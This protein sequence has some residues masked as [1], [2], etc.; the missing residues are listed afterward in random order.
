MEPARDPGFFTLLTTSYA[1]YVGVPLV[2]PGCNALWLYEKAPFALLAHNTEADPRFI[3][4]NKTAQ[5]CF[6]YSWSEFIQLRSRFSAEA[7]NREE[8]QRS[9]DAVATRGFVS[10]YSGLRIAKS[11]RRFRIRDGVIWQLTDEQ[12]ISHGQAAIF[13]SWRDAGID[14]PGPR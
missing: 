11:G 5:S 4:A 9:L 7:P 6:E 14:D 1:R 2:E 8:R 10:G 13:R 3:Y 12:G